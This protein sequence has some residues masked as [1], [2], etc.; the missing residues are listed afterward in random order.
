MVIQ[1]ESG[2]VW[3]HHLIQDDLRSKILKLKRTYP[4]LNLRMLNAKLD[5]LE[6]ELVK[7][8]GKRY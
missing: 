6:E 5:E 8:Y 4:E 7:S 2:E 3:F 1:S